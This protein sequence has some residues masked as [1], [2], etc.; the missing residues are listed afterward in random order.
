MAH[1]IEYQSF[2][3]NV[4]TVRTVLTIYAGDLIMHSDSAY[5]VCKHVFKRNLQ[6]I[7]QW[8]WHYKMDSTIYANL[9]VAPPSQFI[10]NR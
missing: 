4:R 8:I 5:Y 3:L 7:A 9:Y 1:Q 2:M 10:L 6:C